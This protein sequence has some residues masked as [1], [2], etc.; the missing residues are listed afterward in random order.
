MDNVSR[1]I[2]QKHCSWSQHKIEKDGV[3]NFKLSQN[4]G[5]DFYVKNFGILHAILVNHY[6]EKLTALL[7]SS[8]TF[9]SFNLAE[10][11]FLKRTWNPALSMFKVAQKSVSGSHLFSLQLHVNT[12]L[13]NQ[14][15]W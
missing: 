2:Y 5:N 1:I 10:H 3:T 9:L 11:L 4:E 15:L 12:C 14:N 6:T 7:N 13:S 8:W